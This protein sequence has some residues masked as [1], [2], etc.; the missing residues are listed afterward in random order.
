MDWTRAMLELQEKDRVNNRLR[1]LDEKIRALERY[2]G[3]RYEEIDPWKRTKY[4]KI[5]KG[6]E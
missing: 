5:R 2:L 3:V 6:K 1:E 4:V